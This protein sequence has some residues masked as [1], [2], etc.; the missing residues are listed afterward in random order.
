METLQFFVSQNLVPYSKSLEELVNSIETANPLTTED[1]KK[2]S[3][4]DLFKSTDIPMSYTLNGLI[5]NNR[6]GLAYFLVI[7][8]DRL[9][10]SVR[11]TKF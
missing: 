1:E 4:N 11:F 9:Q 6:S 3:F 10:F 5:A 8:N 7:N 2:V